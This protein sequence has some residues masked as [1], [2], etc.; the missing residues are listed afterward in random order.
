MPQIDAATQVVIRVWADNSEP[1]SWARRGNSKPGLCRLSI[2]CGHSTDR[3][4][5][6]R[7]LRI[8]CHPERVSDTHFASKPINAATYEG[9]LRL[10]RLNAAQWRIGVMTIHEVLS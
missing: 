8:T 7:E 10:L 6:F 1:N 4:A 5:I 3:A 2:S 9:V